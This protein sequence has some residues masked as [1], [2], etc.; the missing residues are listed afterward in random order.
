MGHFG[1]LL[2]FFGVS[3]MYMGGIYILLNFCL[4]ALL[5][6]EVCLSQ[7]SGRVEGKLFFFPYRSIRHESE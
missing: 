1:E 7:D 4:L 5:S 6:R 3:P 2:R